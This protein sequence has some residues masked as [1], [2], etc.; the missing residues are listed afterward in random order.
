MKWWQR[1]GRCIVVTASTKGREACAFHQSS[2][3]SP[4]SSVCV[5]HRRHRAGAHTWIGV[6]GG[7]GGGVIASPGRV[8]SQG[9]PTKSNGALG[10]LSQVL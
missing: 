5:L 2:A 10:D 6:G 1:G 8:A 7:G 9:E 4:S 3:F